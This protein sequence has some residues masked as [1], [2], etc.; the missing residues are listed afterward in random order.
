MFT[1]ALFV[2]LACYGRGSLRNNFQTEGRENILLGCKNNTATKV[3]VKL[4]YWV[5]TG[6][7]YSVRDAV[8]YIWHTLPQIIT[9]PHPQTIK[10]CIL[11]A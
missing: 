6:T 7:I 5:D 3:M 11:S 9:L 8:H 1:V 4:E 2:H 10:H